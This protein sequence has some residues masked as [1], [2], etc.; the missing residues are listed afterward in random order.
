MKIGIR[1]EDKSPWERRVPLIPADL[2]DLQKHGIEFAVQAS[3]Q[4]AF[5]D[6]EFR[7]AG[8]AVVENLS[9]CEIIIGI[10]ELAPRKLAAGKIYLFFPHVIKGQPHNMPMLKRMMQL[11]ITLVDYERIVDEQN[12]R[13]I[14]FGRHAGLAGMINSLWAL[15]QRLK[16]E[17]IASPF[18]QL[19]QAVTYADLA[20]V[21]SDLKKV[22]EEIHAVGVPEAVHPLTIGIAGYGNVSRGAQ[23]IVALLPVRQVVPE[24]L[25]AICRDRTVSRH[26]LYQTVLK[27]QH[28]VRPKNPE[29]TFQLDDYFLHGADKYEGIFQR[30]LGNL[31]VLVNCIYWDER[32]PRIVT[33]EQCRNMWRAGRC[34]KLRVIGDISCDVNGSIECT[35]KAADPG[36]PVYVYHPASGTVTDGFEGQGPVIM[37]VDILPA[38]IPR[39]SSTDFSTVLKR[40]IPALASADLNVAFADLNLPPELKCAVILYKGELTPAYTYMRQ[41]LKQQ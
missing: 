21:R 39:E 31:T 7:Q 8:I 40:F 19:R 33:T 35:V 28:L 26:V 15:G 29:A 23:E 4:R 27:E 41:F 37:A 6:D 30:Y 24:K 38:E 36:N 32:Y 22:G 34:A 18:A 2:H 11:G 10:K 25:S 17:G 13:L 14:F 16:V 5:S 20:E 9:D 12:R 3:A 1:H